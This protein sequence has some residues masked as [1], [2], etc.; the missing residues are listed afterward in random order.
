VHFEERYWAFNSWM[1]RLGLERYVHVRISKDNDTIL[2]AL[3]GGL[4]WHR[5]RR[6]REAEQD[7]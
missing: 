3:D 2:A 4:R 5:R 7:R 1:R 6:A